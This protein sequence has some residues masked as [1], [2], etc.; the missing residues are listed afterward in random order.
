MRVYRRGRA[1]GPLPL[2]CGGI[3]PGGHPRGGQEQQTCSQQGPAGQLAAGQ[4]AAGNCCSKG[5]ANSSELRQGTPPD[6]VHPQ[7]AE[8]EADEAALLE[9]AKAASAR[10]AAL[11]NE[12]RNN[13]VKP[14]IKP[15]AAA[16][17]KNA[18]TL[19]ID[20]SADSDGD[21]DNE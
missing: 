7:L 20:L 19:S 18:V 9:R 12:L 21:D 13:D 15:E 11:R 14:E 3:H 16:A 10:I 8:L 6:S 4:L 2:P 17:K 5:G 1:D